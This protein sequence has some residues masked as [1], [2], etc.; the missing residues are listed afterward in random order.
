M[1]TSMLRGP[2]TS[3]RRPPAPHGRRPLCLEV[4]EDRVV[5]SASH[6]GHPESVTVMTYNLNNGSDL[7]PLFSVQSPEQIP[8]AVSQVLAEVDSSNIP[9]RAVALAHVIEAAHPD[10]VGVQEPEP[11]HRRD[12]DPFDSHRHL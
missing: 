11:L 1:F 8:A 3:N 6:F 5:P 7:I 9:A 4:L 10:L 2:R 12:G